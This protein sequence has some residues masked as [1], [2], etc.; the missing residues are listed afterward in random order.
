M[1]IMEGKKRGVE[2]NDENVALH[3]RHWIGVSEAS[4]AGQKGIVTTWRV[5]RCTEK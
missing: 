5:D 4:G 1:K 3:S 2:T